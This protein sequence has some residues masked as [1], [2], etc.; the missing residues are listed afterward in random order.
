[1]HSK[2]SLTHPQRV[3][4]GAIWRVLMKIADGSWSVLNRHLRFFAPV[5]LWPLPWIDD[6][7][8]RISPVGIFPGDTS[9]VQIWTL[10][11]KAFENY[12]LTDRYTYIQTDKQIYWQTRP[13]LYTTPLRGWSIMMMLMMI[14]IDKENVV[15]EVVDRP[16]V[17]FSSATAIRRWVSDEES[18]DDHWQSHDINSWSWQKVVVTISSIAVL[19]VVAGVASVKICRSATG[20]LTVNYWTELS[21]AKTNGLQICIT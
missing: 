19:V 11:V 15:Q 8:T 1:M 16:N 21:L 14:I 18:G 10:Y 12:R 6:F 20:I 3:V 17:T 7:H 9:D 4:Y 2:L 5:T 13:K